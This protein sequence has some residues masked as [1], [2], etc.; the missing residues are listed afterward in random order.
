MLEVNQRNEKLVLVCYYALSLLS[1]IIDWIIPDGLFFSV[2]PS[3]RWRLTET[4]ILLLLCHAFM[5]I[6]IDYNGCVLI[7]Y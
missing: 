5:F 3:Q 6:W 2:Q 7:Y 1:S 4:G